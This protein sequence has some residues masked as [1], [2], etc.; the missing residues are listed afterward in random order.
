MILRWVGYANLQEQVFSASI[1]VLIVACIF[2]WSRLLNVF[3]INHSLGPLFFILIRLFKDIFLWIFVFVIFAVSFQIGFVNLTLQAGGDPTSGYPTGSLPVSFFTIIGDYGYI[4][5]TMAEAPMGIALLAI[6][7]LLAQVMLVN[8]LIA[9]MG[10][11]YSNVSDNSTEEWKFY[12]LELVMENRSA[13]FH[14]PPTNLL[15]LPLDIYRA[16]RNL[17]T[18]NQCCAASVDGGEGNQPLVPGQQKQPIAKENSQNKSS[19][20]GGVLEY[21]QIDVQKVL[22]K[23]RLARDEIVELEQAEEDNSVISVVTGLKERLRT[24]A[25][26]RENDRTFLDKRFKDLETSIRAQQAAAPPAAAAAAG[27]NPAA[28]P[29]VAIVSELREAVTALH[30]SHQALAVQVP[31]ILALLQQ[32]QQQQAQLQQQLL[33]MQL[34]QAPQV[35]Q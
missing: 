3:A 25:N 20:Y 19:F 34:V 11:T 31:Q 7:A 23:M 14:P 1:N 21:D 35:P 29:A 30:S 16:L 15:L 33:H 18:G 9:M 8:L 27:A 13:S 5:D 32:Q 2:S 10:D 28:N 22:K 17:Y 24:L 12:R 6:Y 26:E 4:D